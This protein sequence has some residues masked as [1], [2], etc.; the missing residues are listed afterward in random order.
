[1]STTISCWTQK[2]V[3]SPLYNYYLISLHFFCS[4]TLVQPQPIQ[5]QKFNWLVRTT[6]TLLLICRENGHT[7]RSSM[8]IIDFA[9]PRSKK[10]TFRAPSP[11]L[12]CTAR[13]CCTLLSEKVTGVTG[14]NRCKRFLRF[15][16][17]LIFCPE[18]IQVVSMFLFHVL[19]CFCSCAFSCV[20]FNVFVLMFG[21]HVC[22]PVFSMFFCSLHVVFMFSCFFPD[23]TLVGGFNPFE[24]YARQNGNLP[25]IGVKIKN[26]NKTTTQ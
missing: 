13:P 24:K 17:S 21:V 6:P 3:F 25:Q 22:F 15:Q 5:I 18:K 12:P 10:I 4:N 1:M 26:K 2:N 20:C 19:P 8:L 7:E 9:Q 11:D 16:G 23:I 14:V